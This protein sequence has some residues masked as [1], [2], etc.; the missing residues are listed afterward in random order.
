LPEIDTVEITYHSE[1]RNTALQ[2]LAWL[3][4]QAGWKDRSSS[5]K[6]VFE[7]TGGAVISVVLHEDP[8]APP[9]SSVV[10]RAKN[11][12]VRITQKTGASHVERQLEAGAYKASSLS[13][14]DPASPAEL[15]AVQLARGGKNSLY[16]KILPRF[17]AML[18]SGK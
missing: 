6:F 8:T 12:T 15:V 16:Q 4:V 3:A 2:M 17:R 9:L 10:I 18:E 7:S 5:G 1:H 14:A 13:P 11:A